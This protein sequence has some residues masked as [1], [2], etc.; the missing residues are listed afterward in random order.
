MPRMPIFPRFS[1]IVA[2]VV[3]ILL[4]ATAAAQGQIDEGRAP[5]KSASDSPR[6]SVSG[7]VVNAVTA[8][9]IARAL[10]ELSGQQQFH[11]M[12]DSNGTFRFDGVAEGGATI[13]AERPGY[14]KQLGPGSD[15]QQ[16]PAVLQLNSNL[17]GVQ[18]RL[19]PQAV[20]AGRIVS[21][22][23]MP[24]EDF[25]VRVYRRNISEGRARWQLAGS[26]TSDDD[27]H[28]RVA[29]LPPGSYCL[30]AGPENWRPR[31]AKPLQKGYAEAFYPNTTDF[32]SAS[33]IAVTAGQQVEAD[34]S[35][36]QEPL[37]HVAGQVV[38]APPNIYSSV[39]LTTA[40]GEQIPV[41]QV[42]PERHEFSAYV[43]AGRYILHA[44]AQLENQMLSAMLPVNVAANVEGLQIAV[45]P[46]PV[47]PVSVRIEGGD[48]VPP[49]DQVIPYATVGL[50]ST[51][52]GVNPPEYWAQRL[53][54]DPH[55]MQILNLE[56]G[57]YA[58]EIT[59]YGKYVVSATSGSIDLLQND[60]VFSS[61][62]RIDPIEI[63][64]GNDGGDISGTVRLPD[65]TGSATV[66]LV[67]ERRSPRE[68]RTAVAQG[69][70]EFTF[71]KTR[72]GEYALL[73]F[74]H[75]DDL[76]F[77]NPD[78]LANYM[79]RA[80]H[81]SVAPRQETKANLE[82]IEVGK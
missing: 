79:S 37:Y 11:T 73:A 38:G 22:K 17:D 35:L 63:V 81:I 50:I 40:T 58:V 49:K 53:S 67:P 45:G 80:T 4:W 13:S 29:T 3:T 31:T 28:Y 9:P 39:L 7:M 33:V 61:D 69:S 68:I 25:P 15:Q 44:T 41:V 47:V 42:H 43:P 1:Q 5:G 14:F 57:T 60:L 70:G 48:S 23:G 65:G 74:S 78:V 18:V 77:R 59:S 36:M 27:G 6:Y 52:A 82:L 12:T 32:A 55:Y 19:V 51:A 75:A 26:A 34:F 54:Q 10:V 24:I 66:L 16:S 46:Q 64:L 20:I 21:M 62:G 72:P 8:E 30:S 56:P 2:S 71:D 76:E